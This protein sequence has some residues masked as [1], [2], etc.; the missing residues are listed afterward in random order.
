LG[1]HVGSKLD[2]SL[3]NNRIILT[4]VVEEITLDAL[5]AA[6]PKECFAITDE[7]KQWLNISP[8]GEEV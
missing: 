3:E 8:T 7:D 5:L 6:S 4:P 1:L 2:L